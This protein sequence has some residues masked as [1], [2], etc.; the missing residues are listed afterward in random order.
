M[1]QQGHLQTL[2]GLLAGP[3]LVYSPHTQVSVLKDAKCIL[4]FPV[5]G[6]ESVLGEKGLRIGVL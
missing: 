2:S 1:P 3:A 5:V 6:S 4:T